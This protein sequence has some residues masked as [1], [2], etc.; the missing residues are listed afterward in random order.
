V[1]FQNLIAAAADPGA[2]LLK[3]SQ[4]DEIALIHQFAAKALDVAG[5]GFL[6]FRR[7]AALL[8]DGTRGKWD[9]RQDKGQEKF[10][11]RVPLL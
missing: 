8:G 3:A 10:T 6:L 4:N 5:T 9:R 2:I 1:V 7:T 11:H